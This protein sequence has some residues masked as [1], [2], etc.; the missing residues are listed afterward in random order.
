MNSSFKLRDLDT[1]GVMTYKLVF[2][3]D[4]DFAEGRI[5]ILAPIGTA[6][7]GEKVG[8]AVEWYVPAGTRRLR[9]EEI[10]YQPEAAGHFDE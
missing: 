10:L 5:S 9:V 2:P 1:G 7:I 6:M 3:A 4:A 8:N